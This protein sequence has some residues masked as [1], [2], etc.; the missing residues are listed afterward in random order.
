MARRIALP[1]S[2]TRVRSLAA[3]PRSDGRSPF[4]EPHANAPAGPSLA[5]SA[6]RRSSASRAGRIRRAGPSAAPWPVPP[7]SHEGPRG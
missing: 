1:P 7:P 6:I 2:G 3:R 5:E 4:S